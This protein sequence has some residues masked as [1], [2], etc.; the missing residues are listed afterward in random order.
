MKSIKF[1]I[2]DNGDGSNGILWVID[3]EVLERMQEMAD[4]GEQRYAS[5]DGLQ[6]QTLFFPDN[7]NLED[8]IFLNKI[9]LTT[10]QDL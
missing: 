1:V 5:G 8:W 2:V 7:F 10:M 3:K 4:F 9:H 6:V